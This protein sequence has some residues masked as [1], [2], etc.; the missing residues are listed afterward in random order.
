MECSAHHTD[1]QILTAEPTARRRAAD[2]YVKRF[3][4][5]MINYDLRKI[6]ALIFDV[7]GVLSCETVNMSAS[8]EPLRTVN[9][10]DGYA[11]QLA[12]KLG[13]HIVI[14]TGA[15]SEAVRMRYEALGVGDIYTGCTVKMK[16]YREF[17]EKYGYTDE[18]I[19]YTGDDIP[20]YEVMSAVGCPCCPKDACQEIKDASVYVSDKAGGKGC[21]RD[22]IEQVLRAQGKW[23]AGGEAFGW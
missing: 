22:I 5:S 14:L 11:I 9:V 17:T 6:K 21:G 12:V 23:M 18:E 15:R 10:K 3:E 4:R 19:L 1:F 2:T 8:G 13:L 16:T 7:D 20:D